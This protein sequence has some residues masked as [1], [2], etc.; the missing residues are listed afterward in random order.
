[1]GTCVVGPEALRPEMER[2]EKICIVS[3]KLFDGKIV[4]NKLEK[5]YFM[6]PQQ[7][8]RPV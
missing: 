5:I 3:R 2:E 8:G 6:W 7:V 4:V 1:M